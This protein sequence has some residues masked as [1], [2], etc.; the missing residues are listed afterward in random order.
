MTMAQ[1]LTAA[2]RK[3]YAPIEESI[4]NADFHE[5]CAAIIETLSD[6]TA[7]RLLPVVRET[8]AANTERNGGR[9]QA[10]IPVQMALT[11]LFTFDPAF[12]SYWKDHK[13]EQ[14]E[15]AGIFIENMPDAFREYTPYAK[16]AQNRVTNALATIPRGAIQLK[17]DSPDAVAT[18]GKGKS[19][20]D[21]VLRDALENGGLKTQ[22]Q[23]LL[24]ALLMEFQKTH[25]QITALSI[26]DYLRLRGREVT[27]S[28]RK[29]MRK[30]VLASL[31]R[32]QNIRFTYNE[33]IRGKYY[34]RGNVRLNGGTAVIENSVIKW[35]W[36]I[37]FMDSLMQL[38]PLDYAKETLLADPRT[39]VYY[40]SRFLDLHQRRNEGKPNANT[41]TVAKLLEVARNVQPIEEVK[42]GGR[43]S[44]RRRI[45]EPFFRDLDSID[46][47]LYSVY[48][49]DGNERQPE[50][51]VDYET[52]IGC[53]IVY[54]L[55]GRPANL[56]RIAARKKREKKQGK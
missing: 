33:K 55:E 34:Q 2:Q 56:E 8:V 36:N 31:E 35:N 28:N 7:N 25:Q 16:I 46:R 43:Q 14:D 10:Q 32:L 5:W 24:D 41:V 15:L 17:L 38:P 4:D 3:L 6:S 13:E 49:A 39:N 9:E 29:E 42:K 20:V 22:D 51:I 37:S 48:D 50:E 40:F 44:P 19:K 30:E 47:L 1:K 45:I 26:D 27:A 21:F 54:T 53:K 23:M 18:V 12:K 52:F 11:M